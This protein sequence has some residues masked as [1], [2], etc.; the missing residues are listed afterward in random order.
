M[1]T[2]LHNQGQSLI[3]I[4]IVLV[5]VGLL[6]CGFYVYLSKQIPEIPVFTEQTSEEIITPEDLE[7]LLKSEKPLKHY[8]GFEISGK[9]LVIA[10][11]IMEKIKANKSRAEDAC[12][13]EL[14]AAEKAIKLSIKGMAFRDAYR[15]VAK[16]SV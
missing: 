3:G 7:F 13:D 14:Y 9:S 11:K 12:N 6:G 10:A 16:E 5:I 4:V 15:K 2:D 1:K 8:I